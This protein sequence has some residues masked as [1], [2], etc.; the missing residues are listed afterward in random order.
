MEII[1]RVID[2]LTIPHLNILNDQAILSYYLDEI[3]LLLL[4]LKASKVKN[5]LVRNIFLIAKLMNTY[6]S[7]N[8]FS[9]FAS[10][11]LAKLE[12]MQISFW[13]TINLL[14]K[15]IFS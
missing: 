14:K 3:A 4:Q 15:I 2:N 11:Y 13:F 1:F 8:E 5:V 7:F 10:S 6:L 9:L 12:L